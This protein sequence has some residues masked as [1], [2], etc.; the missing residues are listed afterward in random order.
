MRPARY[1]VTG[2][3]P[4]SRIGAAKTPVEGLMQ[5]AAR[6]LIAFVLGLLLAAPLPAGATA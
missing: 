5:T 2:A 1:T 4:S 3:G 6:F